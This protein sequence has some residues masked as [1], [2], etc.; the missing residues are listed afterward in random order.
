MDVDYNIKYTNW[1]ASPD[2]TTHAN[3]IERSRRF[4]ITD[5]LFLELFELKWSVWRR[6]GV[7]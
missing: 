4:L 3:G 2:G 6:V 1:I 5:W 7:F